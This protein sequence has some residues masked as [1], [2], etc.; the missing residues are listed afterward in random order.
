MFRE[1]DRAAAYWRELGGITL[2]HVE[3][4]A[5]KAETAHVMIKDGEVRLSRVANPSDSRCANTS[6][7]VASLQFFVKSRPDWERGSRLRA[8]LA[9]IQEAILTSIELIPDVEFVVHIYDAVGSTI[10]LRAHPREPVSAE[11][12]S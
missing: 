1:A 12:R 5:A 2:D 9:R 11:P 3:Q 7:L 6:R 8:T 4:A 10:A